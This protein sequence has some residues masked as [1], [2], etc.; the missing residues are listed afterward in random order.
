MP[1]GQL[2]V[3]PTGYSGL[4]QLLE[5]MLNQMLRGVQNKPAGLSQGQSH[6]SLNQE[7]LTPKDKRNQRAWVLSWQ[8][9]LSF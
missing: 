9:L 7:A 5:E 2:Q 8:F 3:C 4:L 6:I 1:G